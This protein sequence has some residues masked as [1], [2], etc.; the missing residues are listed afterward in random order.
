MK[1][2]KDKSRFYEWCLKK[3]NKYKRDRTYFLR[4][5]RSCHRRYDLTPKQRKKVIENC[6]KYNPYYG[7]ERKID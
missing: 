5:C 1:D 3:N 4:L 6:K 7:T 2:C